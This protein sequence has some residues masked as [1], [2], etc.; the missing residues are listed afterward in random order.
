MPLQICPLVPVGYRIGM[1][2]GYWEPFA[3]T[4]VTRSPYCMVNLGGFN[5]PVGK[6]GQ[7]VPV[8]RINP[9]QVVFIMCTGTNIH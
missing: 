1:A 8:R 6:S 3:L 7:V 4:D 5:I 2:I 9:W